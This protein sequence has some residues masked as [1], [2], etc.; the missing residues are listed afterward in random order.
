[1]CVFVWLCLCS[2]ERALWGA[3]LC[4]P[5]FGFY[6][7]DGGPGGCYELM[8]VIGRWDLDS[9]IPLEEEEKRAISTVV[10]SGFVVVLVERADRQSVAGLGPISPLR[11]GRGVPRLTLVLV[12]YFFLCVGCVRVP[13]GGPERKVRWPP[14]VQYTVRDSVPCILARRAV[15]RASE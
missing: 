3:F 14:R 9:L 13:R 1:M 8:A 7:R 2:F 6:T 4:E 11:G 12:Y 5:A 10:F 15:P